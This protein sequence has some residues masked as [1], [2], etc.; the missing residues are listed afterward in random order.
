MDS[1]KKK[2]VKFDPTLFGANKLNVNLTSSRTSEW[3]TGRHQFVR[4]HL[5]GSQVGGGER[6]RN[7]ET[8]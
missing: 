1:F 2:I 3:R 6:E 7:D 8:S 4:W 5:A